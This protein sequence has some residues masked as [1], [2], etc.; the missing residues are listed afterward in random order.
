MAGLG[1]VLSPQS[2]QATAMSALLSNV[3]ILSA[4]VFLIVAGLVTYSLVRYRS[5][6]Q[7][8]EPRQH[9]GSRKIETIWTAMPLLVV[10]V[11]FLVTIRTMAFVD[12]PLNPDRAP[13]LVVTARQWWWE[14]RYPNGAVTADEIHIPVSKRLLA[15]VESADVIHDFW[16]PQLARKMDAVPSRPSYIWLEADVPGSYLGACSEFCG[17]QHAGMRFRVIAD[18]DAD[19]SAWLNHQAES[20]SQPASD[21]AAAGARL[22]EQYKCSDCHAVAGVSTNVVRGPSL[23]H[24]ARRKFLGGELPNTAENI[25]R[26]I[27]TPQSIKP[28]NK[29]PDQ[30]VSTGDLQALTAYLAGL[31]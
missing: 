18:S 4:I 13:D 28:G 29:M 25:G 27:T 22:F 3:L 21:L 24:L 10:V 14:A 9:F 31:Q 16:V 26:W 15:R 7:T 19:F 23:A 20:P 17:M 11:L 12:A 2:P 6:G 30:R 5:R 1:P 8:S